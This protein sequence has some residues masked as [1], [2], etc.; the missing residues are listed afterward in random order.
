MTSVYVLSSFKREG[1][2]GG[3][4]REGEWRREE[5]QG[6]GGR[7]EGSK[8]GSWDMSNHVSTGRSPYLCTPYIHMCLHTRNSCYFRFIFND[9]PHTF[10]FVSSCSRKSWKKQVYF[11][12]SK[13]CQASCIFFPTS[14]FFATSKRL[15]AKNKTVK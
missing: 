2:R 8:E 13:L 3:G 1:R 5:E 7:D 12:V 4:N 15:T 14:F 11:L 9:F 10:W 6:V